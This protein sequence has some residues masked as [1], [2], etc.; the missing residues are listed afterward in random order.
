MVVLSAWQ[1]DVNWSPRNVFHV[2]PVDMRAFSSAKTIGW[3]WK[4][5]FVTD[6]IVYLTFTIDAL[7]FT[8][9]IMYFT[10]TPRFDKRYSVVLDRIALI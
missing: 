5:C 9:Y 7:Q 8:V 3:R 6:K 4:H 2:S 10:K 1:L